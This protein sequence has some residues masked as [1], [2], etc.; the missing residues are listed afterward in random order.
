MCAG[1]WE[2]HTVLY[3]TRGRDKRETESDRRGKLYIYICNQFVISSVY[4]SFSTAVITFHRDN[5][6]VHLS[7][8]NKI[9]FA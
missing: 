9:P 6:L 3:I 7:L 5:S 8:H 4:F 1:M 2:S